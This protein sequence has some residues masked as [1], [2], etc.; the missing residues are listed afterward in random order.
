MRN[1]VEELMAEAI[2]AALN[3]GKE[4]L[5]VTDISVRFL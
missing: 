2:I 1:V 4:A 5:A 3:A